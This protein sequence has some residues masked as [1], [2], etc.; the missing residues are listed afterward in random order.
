MTSVVFLPE[1]HILSLVMKKHQTNPNER[2]FFKITGLY[3][4]KQCQ[5]HER[6]RKTEE[7]FETHGWQR[8]RESKYVRFQTG[9]YTRG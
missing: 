5:G 2:T 9:S 6:Q 1:M 4:S 8:H 3:S 7:L